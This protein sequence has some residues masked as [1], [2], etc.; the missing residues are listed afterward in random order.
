MVKTSCGNR[1]KTK[2]EGCQMD[3]THL[4]RG[5]RCQQYALMKRGDSIALIVKR[6]KVDRSMIHR[7]IKRNCGKRGY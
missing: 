5:K 4:N 1:T 7:K 3:T 6:L 2:E